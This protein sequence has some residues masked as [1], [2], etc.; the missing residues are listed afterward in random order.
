MKEWLIAHRGAQKNA[1][2]NTVAAFREALESV[3]S[4]IELDIHTT[5]DGVVICNHDFKLNGLNVALTTYKELKKSAPDLTT[6]DEAVKVIGSKKPIIV[7]IKPI[8]TAKN[9]IKIL[10]HYKDWR[11]TSFKVA[12]INELIDL[13]I[14]KKRLV[15]LQEHHSFGHIKKAKKL[16]MGGVSI[17]Q[18]LMTPRMYRRAICNN[19][20]IYSWA[21]NS[22]LQAKMFRLLYPR[23]K[24]FT[25]RPDLLQKLN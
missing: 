19:L 11:I 10:N 15:L 21:V 13:G 1:E 4:Q 3:A 7:E 17:N 12:V 8:G 6:F 5:K 16:G 25:D 18:R 14:D 2:E 24:I 9:V 23:L 22:P 20:E